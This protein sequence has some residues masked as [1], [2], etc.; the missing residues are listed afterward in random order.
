MK[1][2][3]AF[4]GLGLVATAA[5]MGF[6]P[7]GFYESVATFGPQSDHFVR[8]LA[9]YTAP[10]GVALIVAAWRA[11]WRIPVLVLGLLQNGLH[12]ASHVVDLDTAATT[13]LGVGTLVGLVLLEVVLIA[14]VGAVFRD[15]RERTEVAGLDED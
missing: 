8:D 3:F 1:S 2:V 4:F 15:G 14:L 10:L 12:V 9:T 11:S 13:A 5:W 6:D 7:G